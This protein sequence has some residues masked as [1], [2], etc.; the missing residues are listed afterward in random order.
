MPLKWEFPLSELLMLENESVQ[1][2]YLLGHS[3][4]RF[5]SDF[6]P[7]GTHVIYPPC[8][9]CESNLNG[10][11]EPLLY[12]W[13][14][15]FGDPQ[16]SVDAGHH[17]YWGSFYLMVDA[18]ARSTFDS[19]HLPFN[20]RPTRLKEGPELRW[21]APTPLYWADLDSE[22]E[23]DPVASKN[24]VCDGC[25]QFSE[26]VGIT[27]LRVPAANIPECGIFSVAQ[28]GAHGPMSVTEE[29]KARLEST[30]LNGLGFYPAGRLM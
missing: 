19:L 11:A 22:V 2:I 26:Q 13:E 3:A 20:Y 29:T 4:R 9:R 30:P 21:P 25:G 14:L 17:C 27:R 16:S 5:D 6:F 28:N 7:C 1:K 12:F 24:Q 8:S 15:E 18:F 10:C 23:A